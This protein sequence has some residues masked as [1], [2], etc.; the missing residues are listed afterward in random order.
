MNTEKYFK[1]GLRKINESGINRILSH[2]KHGF[3]IVSANRSEI[4]SDNPENDL[5]PEYEDWCKTENREIDDKSNMDFW[6]SKRNR[7]EDERLKTQLKS[8]EYAFSPVF[9]G[10][11]GSDGVTDNF[12]PSYI[13]Y[14]HSKGDNKAYLNFDKLFEFGIEIT[15]RYK[16]DSFYCQRPDEAPIWVGQ[17]GEKLN[18]SETKNFKVN[19][20]QNEFFTTSKRK[21]RTSY[22]YKDKEGNN[23][24]E[25]PPQRFTADI[26]FESMYRKSGPSTY[27]ERMKRMK[28]GEVFLD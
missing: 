24:M 1:S 17:N 28:L 3:I 19:D 5:T 12:E 27:F 13:V 6:L 25:T 23:T 2:G 11:K 16:Q 15:K 7:E 8:S 21:K 22:G 18:S 14:C 4:Y 10:Y 26:Q 9:G 20:Y